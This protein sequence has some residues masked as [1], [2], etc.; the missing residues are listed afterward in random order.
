MPGQTK[1][2]AW[3]AG[4]GVCARDS[5]LVKL[6]RLALLDRDGPLGAVAK[7]GS[8]T[9][10]IGITHQP[11]FAVDDLN[12]PLGTSGG[13]ESATGTLLFINPDD[14]SHGHFASWAIL[15]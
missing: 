5:F 2:G 1:S 9:V 4:R 13:A 7:T 6:G 8:E 3:L 14:I 12:R 10:A 11:G 15:P